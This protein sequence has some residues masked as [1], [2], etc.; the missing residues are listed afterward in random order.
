MSIGGSDLL[1]AHLVGRIDQLM[2]VLRYDLLVLAVHPQDGTDELILG[3]AHENDLT[4]PAKQLENHLLV[5]VP[6]QRH[7]IDLLNVKSLIYF[8]VERQLLETLL[9]PLQAHLQV[10]VRDPPIWMDQL[11]FLILWTTFI[12]SPKYSELDLAKMTQKATPSANWDIL[13]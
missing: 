9:Q 1:G 10:I 13:V 7:Q 11:N 8:E 4:D 3:V 6:G 12:N 2:E 5:L